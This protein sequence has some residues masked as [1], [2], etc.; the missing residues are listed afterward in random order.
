MAAAERAFPDGLADRV[1]G[2]RLRFAD[3][4]WRPLLDPGVRQPPVSHG[5]SKLKY[6]SGGIESTTHA[7][8]RSELC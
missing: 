1:D 6:C 4:A 8:L 2:L 5:V 7:R 3:G